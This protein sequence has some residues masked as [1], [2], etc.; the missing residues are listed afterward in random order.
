MSDHRGLKYLFDQP[1]MNVRKARWL[2]MTN[3]FDF[4]I[5]YMKGKQNRVADALCRRVHV[6]HIAAMSSFGTNL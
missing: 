5:R 4:E 3:D 1:D 6:N 2:S